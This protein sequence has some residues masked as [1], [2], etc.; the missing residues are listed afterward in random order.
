MAKRL[1][2]GQTRK[3]HQSEVYEQLPALRPVASPV[4]AAVTPVIPRADKS[5]AK[6]R[7]I[8]DAFGTIN[9]A[10]KDFFTM[11]KSFEETNRQA[12]QV[13]GMLGL[14]PAGGPGFLDYG[15]NRGFQEGRGAASAAELSGLIRQE[16]A[17]NNHFVDESNPNREESLRELNQYL[18]K[19]VHELTGPEAKN[20][21]FLEGALR[22]LAELKIQETLATMDKLQ[23]AEHQNAIKNFGVW[24]KDMFIQRL[25]EYAGNPRGLRDYSSEI[26]RNAERFGLEKD[27]AAETLVLVTADHI[28]EL[29][30]D[31]FNMPDQH[32][33]VESMRVTVD[34]MSNFVNAMGLHDS[35]GVPLGGFQM[36]GKTKVSPLTQTL[37]ELK[38]RFG[39]MT[40]A[41]DSKGAAL[42]EARLVN[43]SNQLLVEMV[44]GHLDSKDVLNNY[45]ELMESEPQ[46]FQALMKLAPGI[47]STWDT[48]SHP[49][50]V[51]ELVKRHAP[52]S[53]IEEHLVLGNLSK[54]DYTQLVTTI[55]NRRNDEAYYRSLR[56]ELES[57]FANAEKKAKEAQIQENLDRVNKYLVS[58]M[59]IQDTTLGNFLKSVAQSGEPLPLGQIGEIHKSF[60][61]RAHKDTFESEVGARN[62]ALAAK[63]AIE[64]GATTFPTLAGEVLKGFSEDVPLET[65]QDLVTQVRNNEETKEARASAEREISR[66]IESLQILDPEIE[67]IMKGTYKDSL[68]KYVKDTGDSSILSQVI[69]A[70]K[71]YSIKHNR[72]LSHPQTESLKVTRPHEYREALDILRRDYILHLPEV[73]D[74]LLDLFLK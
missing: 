49:E 64:Q 74:E 33:S 26:L 52:L 44:D 65:I 9:T 27:A 30:I 8:A 56:K 28:E 21:A 45:R 36:D 57:D 37:H 4:E 51:R 14:T 55:V 31:A 53:T 46:L 20:H 25:P 16:L 61:D 2:R 70:T 66:L 11:E 18:V 43:M 68:L 12:N 1:S 48:Q 69:N 6:L 23:T 50:L 39:E 38:H 41:L 63:E 19:K 3:I 17:E 62:R 54:E 34:M 42:K 71:E 60:V 7:Q 15:V 10:L 24:A 58:H 40:K 22:P 35:A 32:Q 29:F 13:R 59:I 47:E 73:P 72:F 5:S 67:Q